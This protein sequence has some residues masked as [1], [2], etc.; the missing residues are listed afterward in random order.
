[1][2]RWS[3]LLSVGMRMKLFS[4][5][6]GSRKQHNS[7]R[8]QQA[9]LLRDVPG[10]GAEEKTSN[11]S[12]VAT[13]VSLQQGTTVCSKANGSPSPPR[14]SSLNL[15]GSAAAA[16]NW[17]AP[18]AAAAAKNPNLHL[19]LENAVDVNRATSVPDLNC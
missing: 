17:L 18:H 11:L 16:S 4:S 2:S 13:R 19:Q 12:K 14:P 7:Q 5:T 6:D 15:G 8:Q 1:M 9:L 10:S 3:R